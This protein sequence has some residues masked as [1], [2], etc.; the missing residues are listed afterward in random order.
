MKKML[1]CIFIIAVFICGCGKLSDSIFSATPSSTIADT[2]ISES[3]KTTVESEKSI[4][5]N[6]ET[7]IQD[8]A[9]SNKL[10][11]KSET[12]NDVSQTDIFD[13]KVA[14]L[15]G[16][17]KK[18]IVELEGKYFD[19]DSRIH[20]EYS[21]L[22][23]K[24]SISK[25]VIVEKDIAESTGVPSLF[26][27]DFNGD[28]SDDIM[29]TVPNGGIK[30]VLS[31]QMYTFT[32]SKIIEINGDAFK[33]SSNFKYIFKDDYK[34]LVVESE[35]LNKSFSVTLTDDLANL[36]KNEKDILPIVKKEFEP[37]DIDSDGAYELKED[38][39]IYNQVNVKAFI[40]DFNMEYKFIN[41]IW[42]PI[43]IK[44]VK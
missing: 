10:E 31:Y 33:S 38:L 2:S 24:N 15:F 17:S 18:Q 11:V 14:N 12:E 28:K 39:W 8:E 19:K 43:D 5:E 9:S 23:V 40:A 32:D 26:V 6:K 27:G 21:K 25:E 1:L 42:T 20:T 35:A 29:V 37:S 30:S 7:K 16:D 36:Y 4:K 3:L 13:S 22:V 41:G 34:T 44:S